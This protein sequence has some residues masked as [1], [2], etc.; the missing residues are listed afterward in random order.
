MSGR[1]SGRG[2]RNAG[3][4]EGVGFADASYDGGDSAGAGVYFES[5]ILL[6]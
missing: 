1:S 4:L 6:D 3:G 2:A 5:A